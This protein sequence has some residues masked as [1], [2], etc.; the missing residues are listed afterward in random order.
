[1][2]FTPGDFFAEAYS[3]TGVEVS[4]FVF[5]FD[6]Q[7]GDVKPNCTPAPGSFLPYGATVVTCTAS[8]SAG[9]A[10]SASFT[11]TVGDSQGPSF[12]TFPEDG[13]TAYASCPLGALATWDLPIATDWVDGNVPVTCDRNPGDGELPLGTTMVTCTATDSHGNTSTL[14]FEVRVIYGWGGFQEPIANDDSSQ[15]PAGSTVAVRFQLAGES[16]WVA[17]AEAH[18]F[19]TAIDDDGNYW[20]EIPA[21]PAPSQFAYQ[22][23]TGTYDFDLDTSGMG[24]GQY[25]LRA[26]LGDGAYRAVLITLTP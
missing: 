20:P 24:P 3:E 2:L 11:V 8:D 7:D 17:E 25:L 16:A 5:A 1:V 22:G 23:D 4:Y 26:D 15:F 18:L 19:L 14:Q 9:N 13:I 21:P 6:A 12:T 10:A